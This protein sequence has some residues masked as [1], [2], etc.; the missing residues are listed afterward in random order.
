[1]IHDITHN[2]LET[3]SR[4]HFNITGKVDFRNKIE[5]YIRFI[6][7]VRGKED[8][9]YNKLLQSLNKSFLDRSV[10]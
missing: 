9:L 8:H 2:G 3:A 6:G 5:G 1:M 7:Q 10:S 4:K